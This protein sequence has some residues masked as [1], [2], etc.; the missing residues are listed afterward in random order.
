MIEIREV[1]NA[2]MNNPLDMARNSQSYLT[3]NTVERQAHMK[4]CPF[5]RIMKFHRQLEK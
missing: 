4:I 5:Y 2:I 3:K 1:K